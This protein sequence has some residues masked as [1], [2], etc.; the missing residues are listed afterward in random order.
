MLIFYLVDSD[1]EKVNQL[2]QFCEQS[3]GEIVYPQEIGGLPYLSVFHS[4]NLVDNRWFYFSNTV[5][6]CVQLYF[7]KMEDATF[8]KLHFPNSITATEIR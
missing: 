2:I 5:T 7:D 4:E 3:F 8:F 6:N 1:C